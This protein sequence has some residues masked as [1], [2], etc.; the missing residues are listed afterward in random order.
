[1]KKYLKILWDITA[2]HRG[3]YLFSFILQFFIV[4]VMLLSTF[5]TKILV[6]TIML[7]P[8]S[9]PIDA[10]LTDLFGGQAFLSENLWVFSVI[11]LG[12]G[13]SRA[14]MFFFRMYLRGVVETNIGRE[15]QLKLF[16]H[17]ERLPYPAL[18]KAKSGDYIQ[19]CTRDEETVRSFITRQVFG[20]SYALFIVTISFTLLMTL[21]PKI[22][23]VTIAI[24][25]IMFVY[26]YFL[27]RRVR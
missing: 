7:V 10:F 8:P 5:M 19:T 12:L 14:L 20:V 25:P 16:Y 27:I 11:I 4:I 18:K 13:F 2:G 15:M 3:T 23:L 1:M 24:L 6:D 9:G 22:A 21:S 17:I 26:S